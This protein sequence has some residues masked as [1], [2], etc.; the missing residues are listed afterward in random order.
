VRTK[1]ER[2]KR[3]LVQNLVPFTRRKVYFDILPLYVESQEFPDKISRERFHVFYKS[4][5]FVVFVKMA[6]ETR[7]REV[8]AWEAPY[9][10]YALGKC[11]N[12]GCGV[13]FRQWKL[14]RRP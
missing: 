8:Y 13:F 5:K 4:F 3:V 14:T 6:S 9:P 12:V 7:M 10:V 2:S 1:A 11:F